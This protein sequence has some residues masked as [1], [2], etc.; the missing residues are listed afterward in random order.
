[1]GSKPIRGATGLSEGRDAD[2]KSVYEDSNPSRP[3]RGQTQKA[4]VPPCKQNDWERYPVTPPERWLPW[5]G[6]HLGMMLQTGSTPEASSLRVRCN[7]R[8]CGLPNRRIRIV[9]GHSHPFYAPE[10]FR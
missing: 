9:P 8:H 7:W 2:S 3:A 4:A 6:A 5:D 1:M 10:M